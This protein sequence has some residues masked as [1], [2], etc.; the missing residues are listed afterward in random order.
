MKLRPIQ[1]LYYSIAEVSE[2]T[3]LKPHVLRYWESEF[4]ELRPSKNRAGNRIYRLNDIKLLFLIKKLLYEDKFTI[5]G[6]RKKLSTFKKTKSSQLD[7]PFKLNEKQNLI[8]SIKRDLL[9]I[10]D[11]LDNNK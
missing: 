8:N 9:E 11:I 6:T 2:I 10:L 5:E 4:D 1:K 7:M 3:S